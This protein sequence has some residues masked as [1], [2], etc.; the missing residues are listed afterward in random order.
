[1]EVVRLLVNHG[2]DV[3]RGDA[4]GNTPLFTAVFNSRGDGSIIELLRASGADALRENR[5]GQTPVGLAR[6][7]DNYDV[8]RFFTDL[9]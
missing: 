9:P 5:S 6:L 3:N 7:I 8:A 1:V 2:A 4:H